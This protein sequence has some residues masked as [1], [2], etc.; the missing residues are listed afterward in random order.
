MQSVY[1]K[2][3]GPRLM[4]RACNGFALQ[5]R[6]HSHSSLGVEQAHFG[7]IGQV[8]RITAGEQRLLLK[9]GDIQTPSR[10]QQPMLTEPC[11]R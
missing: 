1:I 3:H 10:L 5:A 11:R 9:T 6:H 4:K 7:A 8:L 2:V